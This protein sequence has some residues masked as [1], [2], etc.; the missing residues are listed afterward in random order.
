MQHHFQ[1]ICEEIVRTHDIQGYAKDE[2]KVFV[3]QAVVVKLYKTTSGFEPKMGLSACY[4]GNI[5]FTKCIVQTEVN[6]Y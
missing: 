6:H 3:L 5:F 4:L 1:G 2:K